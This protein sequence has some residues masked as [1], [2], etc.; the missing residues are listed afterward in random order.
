MT[1][2]DGYE[3]EITVPF[4]VGRGV[5]LQ[6]LLFHPSTGWPVWSVAGIGLLLAVCGSVSDPRLLVL[7]L[8]ICVAVS[9]LAVAFV[10][11][12]HVLSPSLLGNVLPHTVIRCAG[13]FRVKIFRKRI[14]DDEEGGEC[15]EWEEFR[16]IVIEDSMIEKVR[17][18]DG[19]KV[20]FL[21]N[22]PMGVLYIPIQFDK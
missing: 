19:F 3:M 7:G 12:C 16:H 17:Y 1:V 13:S 5:I 15:V 6:T 2:M 18:Y 10:Y 11:A 14:R 8:L 20:L 9:P 21:R 4:T 22:A